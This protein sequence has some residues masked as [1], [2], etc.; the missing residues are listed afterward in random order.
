MSGS[1]VAGRGNGTRIQWMILNHPG[2]LFPA[3]SLYSSNPH[4]TC[5]PPTV[6]SPIPTP[7]CNQFAALRLGGGAGRP[8]E[9]AK[10]VTAWW[11]ECA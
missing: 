11:R 5:S 2:T 7:M 4:I 3:N 8:D 1:S 6:N 10:D 9:V